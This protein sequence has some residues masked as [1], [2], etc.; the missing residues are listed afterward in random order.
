LYYLFSKH[1]TK[2][3]LETFEY[4]MSY[5]RD[6]SIQ[7]HIV[8]NQSNCSIEYSLIKT[9]EENSYSF[10]TQI[11]PVSSNKDTSFKVCKSP[12]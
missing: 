11:L 8:G 2:H 6:T 7:T 5:I 12:Y 3:K 1:Y 10:F 4:L 9:W